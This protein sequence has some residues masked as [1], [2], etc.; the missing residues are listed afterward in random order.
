MGLDGKRFPIRKSVGSIFGESVRHMNGNIDR[1][2]SREY[3]R[4]FP[5]SS[6]LI[7]A[8]YQVQ[9]H[10]Q[11]VFGVV[12]TGPSLLCGTT[13]KRMCRN[14][15]WLVW[16]CVRRRS[17]AAAPSNFTTPSLPCVVCAHRVVFFSVSLYVFYIFCYKYARCEFDRLNVDDQLGKLRE[18]SSYHMLQFFVTNTSAV[19]FD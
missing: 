12:N 2:H 15:A 13:T 14:W 7:N 10:A 8:T 17:R 1:E 9:S 5:V 6:A 18:T 16:F 3:G 4:S 11:S 19:K